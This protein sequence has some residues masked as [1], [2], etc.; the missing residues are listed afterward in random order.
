MIGGSFCLRGQYK[1]KRTDRFQ[2][3]D[4]GR[5][6]KVGKFACKAKTPTYSRW[7]FLLISDGSINSL[8][9]SF[10]QLA[11]ELADGGN[12]C[13]CLLVLLG[14]K[15]SDIL[16]V[17]PQEIRPVQQGVTLS[18]ADKTSIGTFENDKVRTIPDCITGGF[19][20]CAAATRT[21][22]RRGMDSLAVR[23]CS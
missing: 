11:E 6:K 5:S 14:H 18:D 13:H 17:G 12:Q 15:G 7:V 8:G 3:K 21:F 22:L 23:R 16:Q 10:C 1:K 19:E 2:L 4:F 20:P 9:F